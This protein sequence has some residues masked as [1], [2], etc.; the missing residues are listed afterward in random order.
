MALSLPKNTHARI[1]LEAAF[2][3]RLYSIANMGKIQN[4]KPRYF[5]AITVVISLLMIVSAYLELTQSREELYRLM[6]EQATSLIETITI[7]GA[8]TIITSYEIEELISQRLLTTGRM[9]ARLDSITQLKPDDLRM[10]AN[11]NNIYRIN[12]FDKDGKKILSNH[13]PEPGH[14][15]LAAKHSPVD[16]I[17]PIL[18]DGEQELVIGLEEA[19]FENGTRY[20]VAVRRTKNKPGAIVFNDL[21]ISSGVQ[22]KNWVRKNY[23]GYR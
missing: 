3:K 1:A 4:I 14:E 6:T 11:E 2:A 16:F 19:R 8:N 7:S 20:A 18:E 22:K 15:E 21:S 5:I 9:I 13:I 12:I 10:Y 23:S 17:K